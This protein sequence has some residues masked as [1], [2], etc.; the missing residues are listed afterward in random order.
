MPLCA[1]LAIKAG[2][3]PF[4]ALQAITI[5][6]AEHIGLADRV[7]SLETG[8]DADIVIADGS[9]FEVSTTILDVLINGKS[10]INTK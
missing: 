4:D 2:M 8:K 3:D 1:G 5:K 9:P 7:G 10:V 6:A